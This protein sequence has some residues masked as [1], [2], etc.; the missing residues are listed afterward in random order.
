MIFIDTKTFSEK[1]KKKKNMSLK[2]LGNSS[3]NSQVFVN[4]NRNVYTRHQANTNYKEF[5]FKNHTNQ[6]NTA[7]YNVTATSLMSINV[8]ISPKPIM[9]N[10]MS[11]NV[12]NSNSQSNMSSKKAYN[13]KVSIFSNQR[14]YTGPYSVN[15][16]MNARRFLIER[17]NP[18]NTIFNTDRMS[19][20]DLEILKLKLN[21][22]CNA[23]EDK[24]KLMK[25]LTNANKKLISERHEYVDSKM[26]EFK[27][28]NGLNTNKSSDI[29]LKIGECFLNVLN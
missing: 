3:Q 28:I 1:K 27:G 10:L 25:Q 8:P 14:N 24:L 2:R 5:R 29:D 7:N 15:C 12:N 6:N 22:P 13:P 18:N 19:R 20:D 4:L 23:N 16:I 11:I 17:L 26:K 21:I 9:T